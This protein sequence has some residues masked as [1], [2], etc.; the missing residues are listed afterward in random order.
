MHASSGNGREMTR[1]INTHIEASKIGRQ[2]AEQ[3]LDYQRRMGDHSSDSSPDPDPTLAQT[4][5]LVS[6]S[7]LNASIMNMENSST[8]SE[9]TTRINGTYANFP[10]YN[11]QTGTRPNIPNGNFFLKIFK[12]F[13]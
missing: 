4:V 9:P 7:Q 5:S 1:M 2:I 10:N 11:Q 13:Y 3:V 12:N 8:S 6:E